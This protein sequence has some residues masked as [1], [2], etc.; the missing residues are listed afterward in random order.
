MREHYFLINLI[1]YS[2][3][4][5]Y[6]KMYDITNKY[7]K[8]FNYVKTIYYLHDER[9]SDNFYNYESNIL[10]VP[11]KNSWVPGLL[12]KTI[13]AFEY[14][15]ENYTYNYIVRPNI[16]TVVN[17][18]KLCNYLSNQINND[19]IGSPYVLNLKWIDP[20][21]GVTDKRYWGL[22]FPSGTSYVLSKDVIDKIIVKK[23]TLHYELVDDLSL[24]VFYKDNNL[25]I[26]KMD[27]KYFV[28]VQY[29]NG[30]PIDLLDFDNILFYRN[31][32]DEDRNIDVENMK[33]IVNKLLLPIGI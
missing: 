11:G 14:V 10:Y 20:I 29:F 15:N 5:I 22:N 27:E 9:I 25:S 23:Q 24:G 21:S 26:S 1:L 12:D 4:E 19:Y 28:S 30:K 8:Q 13:K 3:S 31:K 7:Y 18:P 16:S 33:K 32:T 2:Q 17:I 6:D